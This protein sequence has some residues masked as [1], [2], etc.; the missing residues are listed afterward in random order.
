MKWLWVEDCQTL[1]TFGCIC[2]DEKTAG[3]P[4]PHACRMFIIK[5]SIGKHRLKVEVENLKS[6]DCHCNVYK[7][8]RE[9]LFFMTPPNSLV[10][11]PG[12][13]TNLTKGGDTLPASVLRTC[14]GP[15][16]IATF[17]NNMTG[18]FECVECNWDRQSPYMFCLSEGRLWLLR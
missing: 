12:A 17:F 13:F 5:D 7:L 9:R 11:K 1:E 8:S 4:R 6:F 3:Q 10:F 18:L 16:A 2:T 15:Y 14:Q